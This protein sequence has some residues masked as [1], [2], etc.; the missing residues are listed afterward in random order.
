MNGRPVGDEG[1]GERGGEE[2][3]RVGKSEHGGVRGGGGEFGPFAA[4]GELARG[5]A[6]VGELHEEAAAQ[7]VGADAA[8]LD[9]HHAGAGEGEDGGER[10]AGLPVAGGDGVEQDNEERSRDREQRDRIGGQ[11]GEGAEVK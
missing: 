10:V 11:Q 7:P 8:I 2:R 3:A 6:E 9:D 1:A 4:P 5:E